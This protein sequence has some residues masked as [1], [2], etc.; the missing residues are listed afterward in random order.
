MYRFK[1]REVRNLPA[2][3]VLYDK[4]RNC[5][6]VSYRKIL[7]DTHIVK[8]HLPILP[9][10]IAKVRR[11]IGVLCRKPA[12]KLLYR[13]LYLR[14][15]SCRLIL[16]DNPRLL[17]VQN[18]LSAVKLN[19][20]LLIVLRNLLSEISRACVDNEILVPVVVNVHLDKVVAASQRAYRPLKALCIAQ[21]AVAVQALQLGEAE[22]SPL[23]N[24]LSRGYKAANNAVKRRKVKLR[25]PKL[26]RKHSA[27]DI[28]AHDVRNDH[29]AEV[30]RK[31]DYAA[32]ARVNIGHNANAAALCK[33]L[34]AKLLELSARRILKYIRVNH[35]SIIC[36][37]YKIH[38]LLLKK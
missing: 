21:L 4:L 11:D 8:I 7:T 35:G 6:A 12:V 15:S 17:C 24:A 16:R 1:P 37:V 34:R 3:Q 13:R 23:V 25:L 9:R 22:N 14:L 18:V 32:L 36:S 27:A 28:Y 2:E 38:N 10:Q 5:D 30:C 19:R 29:L 33:L 26:H 20:K 31:A